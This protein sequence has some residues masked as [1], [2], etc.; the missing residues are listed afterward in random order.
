MSSTVPDEVSLYH[1][2]EAGKL[3]SITPHSIYGHGSMIG[4][5]IG[6]VDEGRLALTGACSKDRSN[7]QLVFQLVA[8]SKTRLSLQLSVAQRRI[9]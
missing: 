5:G 8:T 3:L 6:W 9:V 7:S 4:C 1:D 2:W